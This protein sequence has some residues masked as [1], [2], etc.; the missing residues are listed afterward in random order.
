MREPVTETLLLSERETWVTLNHE[1]SK[2]WGQRA[3]NRRH[4]RYESQELRE[5]ATRPRDGRKAAAA[6]AEQAGELSQDRQTG[7]PKKFKICSGFGGKLPEGFNETCACVCT[8]VCTYAPDQRGG[9][10]PTFPKDDLVAV[11]TTCCRKNQD[12]DW[13]ARL[14]LWQQSR[15]ERVWVRIYFSWVR[16]EKVG[17][18]QDLFS[19]LSQ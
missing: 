6:E 12:G 16:Q 19:K 1:P 7:H 11:C 15:R 14:G 9:H 18:I 2:V 3:P 10:A 13:R 17:Q 8:C 5:R 4:V